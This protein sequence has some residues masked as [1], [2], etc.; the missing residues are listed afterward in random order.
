MW[1]VL[2]RIVTAPTFADKEQTQAALWLNRL[3]LVLIVLLSVDSLL[4]LFGLLDQDKVAPILSANALGLVINVGALW[5]MRRGHVRF[6]ASVLLLVLFLLG[7]YTNAFVFHSIRTP[8]I[9]TYFAFIPLA[10]LLL[11][12]RNMNYFAILCILTIGVIFVLEWRGLITP[13]PNTRS[14]IDDLVVLFLAIAM[15][16]VLLN[17]S[18]RRVEENAE[19][20]KRTA[21]ALTVVNHELQIS[22][23]QLQQARDELEDRVKLRTNE[24]QKTN[25]QL[26]TEIAVRKRAEE[27]LAHDALHDALTQLPN[28]VLLMDR[29][30]HG[31][32]LAKHNEKYRFFV[33]FLDF[34]Q[35]KVVNDSLGHPVGDQLLIAIAHRLLTCVCPGDTVARLGGDEFVI[36]L[37]DP[38]SIHDAT[39]TTNH[40][41]QELKQTFFLERH[42]V[43]VSTSIGIVNQVKGYDEAEEILRDADIAMYRAKALG[44]DRCE[45]FTLNMREQ[46]ITR[47]ELE[48]DLRNAL[49]QHQLQ[50]Y[51]QPIIDLQSN[52]V[53]GFEALLRWRHPLRGLVSPGEFVPI[54]EETGLILP[55]GLWVLTEACHQI[56]IW[57]ERFPRK[58]PL[59]I[60]VNI[61]AKQF[62]APGFIEQVED[63]VR[64]TLFD[65]STLKLEITEGVYLNRSDEVDATFKKLHTLGIQFHIDDFGT[66][67]SSLSYLQY[68]PIQTVK[69]D[70]AFVDRIDDKDNNKD[71]V[72]TIVA[73][74]HD[75]GMET[76][77]EGIETI[78][79]LNYLKKLGCNYGQGFLLG[80]PVSQEDTEKLLTAPLRYLADEPMV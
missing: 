45:T 25:L 15:N 79:Q 12:R 46:V 7:T 26:H 35:F 74:A 38:E 19:E 8:N 43:F 71:I 78:A 39:S 64:Q 67:Y 54:A 49:E 41:Q 31:L 23:T 11:G 68:F 52:Q 61:S 59:T 34:D 58:P 18:I 17:A 1:R 56:Q 20:I 76:V 32:D 36:I 44:K 48:N 30:R 63:V 57:Q 77:A 53:T 22:Q 27:Q 50:L 28:R 5:L 6:V 69:I 73:M 4:V 33:L 24:L 75:L 37:E 80:R 40:I 14:I 3:V 65:P 10:G 21:A 42:E 55:I 66:G 9:M 29:L 16:T 51:Y 62:S 13:A 70:R 2:K 47:L 60:S 72:R